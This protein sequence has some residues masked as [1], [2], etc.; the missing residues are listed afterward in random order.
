MIRFTIFLSLL[1]FLAAPAS[2]QKTALEPT[3]VPETI[4]N[5]RVQFEDASQSS[6]K[7]T[8]E[9]KNTTAARIRS[10]AQQ[11]LDDL[12]AE[13][14]K[15]EFELKQ[16]IKELLDVKQLKPQ[17]TKSE[18]WSK[19]IETKEKEIEDFRKKQK[20]NLK[21]QIEAKKQEQQQ[22]L[23]EKKAELKERLRV[24]KDERKKAIVENI[25]ERINLLNINQTIHWNEALNK[26]TAILE[27]LSDRIAEAVIIRPELDSKSI[28]EAINEAQ[29]AIETARTA[30]QNQT[31]RVYTLTINTANTLKN[32]VGAVRQQ[33]ERDLKEVR[34]LV[35]KARQAVRNAVEAANPIINK[36]Q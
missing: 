13:Q 26:L 6:K 1:L 17:D 33:A 14:E 23:E 5:I 4:K 31:G 11:R 21:A 20:E 7:A 19:T 15:I 29:T 16:K 18:S 12:K 3:V 32:D 27:K 28:Q 35:E 34:N 24:I 10:E 22:I 2:A 8:A 9:E 25:S 36:K 30:V